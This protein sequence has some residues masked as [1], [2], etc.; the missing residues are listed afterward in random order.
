LLTI[1]TIIIRHATTWLGQYMD[2][3]SFTSLMNTHMPAK[4]N[5]TV[6]E[7]TALPLPHQTV[8]SVSHNN[9]N[10]KVFLSIRTVTV[11]LATILLILH[12][13]EAMTGQYYI[14]YAIVTIVLQTPKPLFRPSLRKPSIRT[15][16]TV[17]FAPPAFVQSSKSVPSL[18]GHPVELRAG[19]RRSRPNR[20]SCPHAIKSPVQDPRVTAVPVPVP[21]R[22]SSEES[23]AVDVIPVEHFQEAKELLVAP[24]EEVLKSLWSIPVMMPPPLASLRTGALPTCVWPLPL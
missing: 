24:E 23:Q 14:A 20:R 21:V 13:I 5:A 17:V 7:E 16:A 22:P 18:R 6:K 3:S 15:R 9:N 8:A 11:V 2:L 12:A 19:S 10:K 4:P 1:S